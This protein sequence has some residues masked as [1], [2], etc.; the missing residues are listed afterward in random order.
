MP[1]TEQEEWRCPVS[2]SGPGTLPVDVQR[3]QREHELKRMAVLTGVG[4]AEGAL[5]AGLLLRRWKLGALV[6]AVGVHFLPTRLQFIA[7][8]PLLLLAGGVGGVLRY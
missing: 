3:L 1:R 8:F 2:P 6:G 7:Q 4:A 5:V